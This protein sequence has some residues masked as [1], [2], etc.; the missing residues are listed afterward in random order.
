MLVINKDVNFTVTVRYCGEILL[1]S[2]YKLNPKKKKYSKM[3]CLIKK[4]QYTFL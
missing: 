4:V 2:F 1:I 3:A